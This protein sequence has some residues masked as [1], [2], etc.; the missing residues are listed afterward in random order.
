MSERAQQDA[1]AA[2][3]LMAVRYYLQQVLSECSHQWSLLTHG[4]T[5]YH[6][7]VE[8]L[9]RWARDRNECVLYVTFNYDNL[10]ERAISDVVKHQFDNINA[11][12][13]HQRVKVFKLHGS[14]DWA[15]P[16]QIGPPYPSMAE[17]DYVIQHPLDVSIPA[18]IVVQRNHNVGTRGQAWVPAL[19]VPIESKE[20]F[21]CP[22]DHLS[23]L[24]NL[25]AA[26]D[27]LL[28]IG[29]RG[30]E[31]HFLKM[32]GNHRTELVRTLVACRGPNESTA[33]INRITTARNGLAT[34]GYKNTANILGFSDLVGSEELER[35][36][37]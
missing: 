34:R 29:W 6:Y 23:L 20:D 35:F 7:L 5:N 22:P 32:L 28:I 36:L 12:I 4:C 10:L 14:V 26:V 18:G 1:R 30:T 27:G 24:D 21:E 33:T 17:R 2:T 11:Y 31:Q 8:R 15:H 25:L 37:A 16:V 13:S 3:Q 19:A 9:D